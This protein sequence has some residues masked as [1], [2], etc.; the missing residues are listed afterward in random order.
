M[1][2]KK[3][4]ARVESHASTVSLLVSSEQH[5]VKAINN[6]KFDRCQL[7]LITVTVITLN[8]SQHSSA[9][10]NF[11]IRSTGNQQ[12]APS[13]PLAH[14]LL[15]SFL[16][17]EDAWRRK[18]TTLDAGNVRQQAHSQHRF[19]APYAW[20]ARQ[21]AHSQHRFPAPYAWSVRHR[22]TPIIAFRHLVLG[23]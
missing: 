12:P 2:Y 1:C 17:E 23:V 13:K 19:P 16:Q 8:F 14:H 18:A 21:Q 3:L 22:H 7:V 5:Y 20:R 9:H 15:P 11:G 4:F 6:K 10:T